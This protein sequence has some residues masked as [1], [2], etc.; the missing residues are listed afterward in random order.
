MA[1]KMKAGKKGP[2]YK[3]FRSAFKANIPEV[4]VKDKKP[5]TTLELNKG[6]FEK[7]GEYFM[8]PDDPLYVP[9]KVSKN[10]ATKVVRK[11]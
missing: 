7:D 5:E 2:M 4:T 6:Y 11:K 3:N 1:F 10:E 8:K 9:K